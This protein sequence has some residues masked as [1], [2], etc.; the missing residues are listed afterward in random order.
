V[1]NSSPRE[2]TKRVNRS[3]QSAR[4]VLPFRELRAYLALRRV[5]PQ[6]ST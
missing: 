1:G 5:A 6:L 4:E 2:V 3:H